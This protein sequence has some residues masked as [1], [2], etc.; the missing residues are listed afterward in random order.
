MHSILHSGRSPKG[1]R[2]RPDDPLA[3]LQPAVLLDELVPAEP[4]DSQRLD[5]TEQQGPELIVIA[6]ALAPEQQ[7][8]AVQDT[9]SYTPV[10]RPDSSQLS[11]LSSSGDTGP[12]TVPSVFAT[13]IITLPVALSPIQEPAAASTISPEMSSA[14]PVMMLPQQNI[15]QADA[16]EHGES[17][18]KQPSV[19]ADQTRELSCQTDLSYPEDPSLWHGQ[20]SAE[21]PRSMQSDSA[22]PPEPPGKFQGS[23]DIQDPFA[24]TFPTTLIAPTTEQ[25]ELEEWDTFQAPDAEAPPLLHQEPG[26]ELGNLLP[27]K[28]SYF[29]Q[30]FL[31]Q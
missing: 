30:I 13:P 7:S 8:V 19:E 28:F 15:M 25:I 21:V 18:L 12:S 26:A 29:E 5:S 24:A 10:L 17:V 22:W 3:A 6:P 9:T 4:S 11:G 16:A 2:L 23:G 27:G 31:L 14:L 1:R 20:S